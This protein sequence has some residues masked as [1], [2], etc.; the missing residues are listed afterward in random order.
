VKSI[1]YD[2]AAAAALDT[3]RALFARV[4]DAITALE[5]V[6]CNDDK[7]GLPIVRDGSL[8]LIVFDK[9]ASV[10]MPGV[11]CLFEYQD[12]QILIHELEFS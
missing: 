1:C 12:D 6:L 11:E 4:D 7:A 10:K 5:W 9:A 2:H 3:A 8:R